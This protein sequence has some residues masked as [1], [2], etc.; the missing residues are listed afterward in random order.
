MYIVGMILDNFK[1]SKAIIYAP[2][3][4]ISDSPAR[5]IAVKHGAD[6]TF[7]EL[8]S[9]EGVIRDSKRTLALAKFDNLERPIG[10]QLFG[11]NPQ[12]MAEAAKIISSLD[13]DFI[14]LNFGC[15]VR[16]VIAKNGG[17]SVLR[18]LGL[19]RKII[20]KVVEATK[21]PVTIKMRSGWDSESLVY[22]EGGKIAEDCGAAAVTLHPR[23]KSQGFSGNADWS[24]IAELKKS[25]NIPVIGNGDVKDVTD[26]KR[27]FDVTGCDGVMV[28]RASLGNPWMFGRIKKYLESGVIPAEPTFD[29][30]IEVA[31][32]HFDMALEEFGMTHGIYKMRS[33]F[34]W[35]I[36]GMPGASE[37]R[38]RIN[39]SLS[40][41]EIKDI[42]NSYKESLSTGANPRILENA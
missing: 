24:Q 30:K 41:D 7:S 4:G 42:V 14:D 36:K 32:E 16:K 1:M 28:G 29:E 10:L 20:S 21:L 17:S 15:P 34:G 2:L 26:V 12:S 39:H 38:L 9:S 35:Y 37:I 31:L 27:M 25:V 6:M 3:A 8:I 13:P 19:F 5:R 40:V 11:A 33:R 18:D 22:L 23:T